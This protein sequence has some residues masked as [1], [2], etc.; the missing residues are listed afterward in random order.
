MKVDVTMPKLGESLTEGTILKWWKAPGDRVEKDEVLLEVSTDKVD[1]EIPSPVSGIVSEILAKE[2]ETVEVESVIARI[3]IEAGGEVKPAPAEAPKAA[4][5]EPKKSRSAGK[6]VDVTMPKLGESLTEGT[7]LK[8]MKSVGENVE[9]DETL[10]EVSTDKVDSEIPS[11]VSGEL[12]EILVEENQTVEVD[13]VLARIRTTED[14]EA[15]AGKEASETAPVIAAPVAAEQAAATKPRKIAG[16]RFYS[17]LVRSI[18]AREGITATELDGIPGSGKGGRLTKKDLLNWLSKRTTAPLSAA[19]AAT[20]TAPA[21]KAREI[22]IPM[23]AIRKKI[24]SHMRQSL[25]TSAHVYSVSECDMSAVMRLMHENR[26]AFLEEEGFK[27]TVTPFIIYAVARAL[28]DFPRVN[29]SIVGESI[30][31]KKYVNIGIAVASDKGLIVPVIKGAE[32][33]NFR[34]L[35]RSIN[36]LVTRTRAN[37]LTV[38]DVQGATFTVTN[39]GIFGNIIGFPIINQPNVAILGVGA[40]KKRP[41]VIESPEG[42][43]LGIRPVTF[44]SMSYDHRLVD[45]ELGGRFM[46]RVVQYLENFN[47]DLI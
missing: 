27:L 5:V 1:S 21:G 39:Y 38:D 10:L 14:V 22:T 17:P 33:L 24:A 7:V 46:Q 43:S 34:G 29:S 23:D 20:P 13:T 19:P 40:I 9:K 11:P 2:N 35:A 30:V 25:D 8:W 6:L 47:Q 15:E 36:D 37:K 4:P 18:A 28:Q 44:I 42:D 16:K 45:G 32:N 26:P 41:V 31:E 3:E 12:A